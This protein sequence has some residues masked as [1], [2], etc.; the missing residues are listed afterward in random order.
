MI[1][2]F[3][4]EEFRR[5]SYTMKK[6]AIFLTTVYF[7][8]AGF[9]AILF[10]GYIVKLIGYDFLLQ[11]SLISV[12]L[13]GV[14]VGSFGFI[15]NQYWQVRYREFYLVSAPETLPL[16][17]RNTFLLS[18][19]RDFIYYSFFN[20][21]P[22]IL[23]LL[24]GS[25][26]V[27]TSIFAL[28]FLS[29]FLFLSFLEGLAISFMLSILFSKNRKV[30]YGVSIIITVLVLLSLR[31]N[32]LLGVLVPAYIYYS[33]MKL[34]LLLTVLYVLV[35]TIAGFLATPEEFEIK[36]H[37]YRHAFDRFQFKIFRKYSTLMSKEFIDMLRGDLFLKLLF[38][39]YLPVLFISLL[40]TFLNLY[41]IHFVGFSALF[42]AVTIS[43]FSVVIYS[44]L[45]SLDD[46]TYYNY[47]PVTQEHLIKSHII[48]YMI[49]SSIVSVPV[50]LFITL[51]FNEALLLPV[52]LLIF[53]I[54]SF[55]LLTVTIYFTGLKTGS[56]LFDPSVFGKFM[57]FSISGSIIMAILGNMSLVNIKYLFYLLFI[58]VVLLIMS[59]LF[60]SKSMKK[61]SVMEF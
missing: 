52:V 33:D 46:T 24:V 27:K 37:R 13:F 22:L 48:S 1:L 4:K 11:A 30:F 39:Y 16:R 53:F 40:I 31:F 2:Y 36:M 50:I 10:K 23:G 41:I 57:T 17:Y 8:A 18:Y 45:V 42:F 21:M 49:L 56:L 54:N 20:F 55:Y 61:W 44:W 25:F 34:S 38:S 32:E 19:I 60:Y 51:Y 35:F 9:M 12:F 29:A 3:L 59:Y 5:F 7:F 15:G 47:L 26:F 28:S 6:S 14:G 43:L 58:L